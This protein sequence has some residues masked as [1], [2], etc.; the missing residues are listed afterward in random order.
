MLHIPRWLPWQKIILLGYLVGV[1]AV[2]I[3]VPWHATMSSI[4]DGEGSTRRMYMGYDFLWLRPEAGAWP[5]EV[6]FVTVILELVAL[7]TV[8]GIAFLV[9][10]IWE[11]RRVSSN[12]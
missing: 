10:S 1:L 4:F 5:V 11:A 12:S 6:D 3:Y 8:T 7:T 9:L 2:S